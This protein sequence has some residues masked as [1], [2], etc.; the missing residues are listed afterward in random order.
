MSDVMISA[1]PLPLSLEE[2]DRDWLTR[3][4]RTRAPGVGL[5]GF[6]VL[7]VVHGTCTKVR[8]RLD[9]DEAAAR[10]G[11]PQRVILKT[12]F[13]PHSRQMA[14]MHLSEV[15]AYRDVLPVLKLP[16]P[17]CYFAEFDPERAQG[18]VIM[19]DLAARGVTFCHPLQ[20]HGRDQVARRLAEL[21]RFHAQTWD[22]PEFAPGGRW[23][24][25]PTIVPE[26][27]GYLAQ[28]LE[29]EVWR[30]FVELPRGRAAS[31]YFQERT[32]MESALQRLV[33]LATR[34]PHVLLHGDTHL[35]NLYVEADGTPGFF[36]S[37]PHRW[38]ALQEVAYHITGAL[39]PLDRRRWDRELVAFYL[40]ELGRHGVSAP[41]ALD[42]A[43]KQF[44]AFL[45]FGFCIFMVNAS[46]FQPEA[47]NTAYTARFSAAMIDHDT[48][49]VLEAIC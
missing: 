25:V 44:A 3:A 5:H 22:S 17:T 20:P 18:V 1:R 38:P 6:E 14:H 37:L 32:W 24:W 11:I 34:Q 36:D 47:I 26:G 46:A 9:R 28:F 23:D 31:V 7:D 19:E 8:L 48:I 49:G 35:G 10:A 42:E 13:E 2:I 29:P 21:A 45:A 12:G 40:R 16:S 15:Q 39:D 4:L 41:P 30:S 43:M 33:A 27:G